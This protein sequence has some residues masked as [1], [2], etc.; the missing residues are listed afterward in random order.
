MFRNAILSCFLI[1]STGAL[2]AEPV[3]LTLTPGGGFDVTY[4]LST[5]QSTNGRDDLSGRILADV[6]VNE[7][8]HVG[9]FKMSGGRIVHSDGTLDL[10]LSSFVHVLFIT[11][12]VASLPLTEVGGGGVN[13]STGIASNSGHR[14]I[15]NEGLA[16]TRYVVFGST[17]GEEVRDLAVQPDNTPLVG[18]TTL[19]AT[20]LA[21]TRGGNAAG[22][23]CS[24]SGTKAGPF[25]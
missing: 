22:S 10:A 25:L 2:A 20:V 11:Q 9:W 12:G 3:E 8:G 18:T 6:R 23:T 19:T 24:I 14:M 21:S 7:C 1:V 15:S 5:G 17:A 16:K 4:S 13:G